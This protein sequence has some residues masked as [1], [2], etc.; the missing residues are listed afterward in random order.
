MLEL[1]WEKL[2]DECE[3]LGGVNFEWPAAD[4]AMRKARF[5]GTS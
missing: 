4:G 5:W 2:I 3:E 1:I